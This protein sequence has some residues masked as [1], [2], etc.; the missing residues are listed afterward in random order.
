MEFGACKL[1]LNKAVFKKKGREKAEEKGGL[2]ETSLGVEG[3]V[4][5]HLEGQMWDIWWS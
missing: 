1:Y 2:A 3:R 4:G 5:V